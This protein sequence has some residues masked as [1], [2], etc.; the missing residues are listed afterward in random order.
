MTRPTTPHSPPIEMVA[1]DIFHALESDKSPFTCHIAHYRTTWSF[2][3]LFRGSIAGAR[4][5][6]PGVA[7]QGRVVG[8]RRLPG[9]R[10]AGRGGCVTRWGQRAECQSRSALPLVGLVRPGARGRPEQLGRQV[11]D[12]DQRRGERRK[13]AVGLLK[14]RT[15]HQEISFHNQA[16]LGL[17]GQRLLS[18]PGANGKAGQQ[19]DEG[20]SRRD[21]RAL[22]EQ[23]LP[24][25]RGGQRVL[26]SVRG[27]LGDARSGRLPGAEE[28]CIHGVDVNAPQPGS[29]AGTPVP[30]PRTSPHSAPGRHHGTSTGRRTAS[31][32]VRA[33]LP[34]AAV[35]RPW[36]KRA[37]AG[38]SSS[39]AVGVERWRRPTEDRATRVV[40]QPRDALAA[41]VPHVCG[42]AAVPQSPRVG[43]PWDEPRNPPP[44]SRTGRKSDTRWSPRAGP[45]RTATRPPGK[46]KPHDP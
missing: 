8:C 39:P 43:R 35:G 3:Q 32:Q 14:L 29:S 15:R 30:G 40:G 33:A 10:S 24:P 7:F 42:G 9:Q 44:A 21:G 28:R 17:A 37:R 1:W 41:I 25:N 12:L 5:R 16:R 38:R 27:A 22:N 34:A 11:G 20:V 19:F 13:L 18:G 31:S 46:K 2:D 4:P 23:D 36:D 45:D 26:D 6:W